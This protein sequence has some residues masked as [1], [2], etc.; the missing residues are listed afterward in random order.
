MKK[1]IFLSL[2]FLS[3]FASA[4]YSNY[5]NGTAG[6][7][8]VF[9][10]DSAQGNSVIYC[11]NPYTFGS[12]INIMPSSSFNGIMLD[13]TQ[14]S[15]GIG[16]F[17]NPKKEPYCGIG[18]YAYNDSTF[19]I[20]VEGKNSNK[21]KGIA[22]YQFGTTG[23]QEQT[24]EFLPS[25]TLHSSYTCRDTMPHNGT[26]LVSG[27]IAFQ[28]TVTYNTSSSGTVATNINGIV[29]LDGT[30]T[31]TYTIV[32]YAGIQSGDWFEIT[33][34]QDS[35]NVAWSGTYL[36]TPPSVIYKDKP[37]KFYYSTTNGYMKF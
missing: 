12:S 3:F 29:E 18:N 11:G 33:T 1:L 31:G 2:I 21:V 15:Y 35:V 37:V 25:K 23:T 8:P 27:T 36:T 17:L 13:S 5:I 10:G 7:L 24:F 28:P 32:P 34:N 22:I 20:W 4:Q 9:T 19:G 26:E 6:Y 16:Y 30:Q 14:A